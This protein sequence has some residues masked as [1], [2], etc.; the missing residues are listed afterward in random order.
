MTALVLEPHNDDCAL[1][2]AFNAMRAKAHV[3]TVLRSHAQLRYR[4]PITAEEREDETDHAMRVLGLTHEQWAIPDDDPDWD[5]VRRGLEELRDADGIRR[6]FAP[7]PED[8]G[9]DHHNLI[10]M[11]AVDVFGPDVVTGYLTYTNGRV[12]STWGEQVEPGP[13]MV[14]K[15]LR[16]LACYDSQIEHQATGH[17]FLNCQH[18]YVVPDAAR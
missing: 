7:A 14:Q 2:T 9:H 4:P 8:G 13:G 6:V 16:A 1:F 5:A 17:H 3:V 15:K 10:G 11:L 18:E 12:R